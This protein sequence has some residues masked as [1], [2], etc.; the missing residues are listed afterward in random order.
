[1]PASARVR[2]VVSA[3]TSVAEAEVFAHWLDLKKG[4]N[5]GA[6]SG[7]ADVELA[8]DMLVR[9]NLWMLRQRVCKV[10]ERRDR[11]SKILYAIDT[12]ERF[13]LSIWIV[14]LA[15]SIYWRGCIAIF[16]HLDGHSRHAM[17]LKKWCG[18]IEKHCHAKLTENWESL[19]VRI[20][21][22]ILD[23]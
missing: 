16:E 1:L 10:I 18:L 19:G 8:V 2:D 17:C 6:Q 5:W 14:S 9:S 12:C 11:Q 7:C 3:L 15:N 21:V 4:C 22:E 23:P 20:S 13:E